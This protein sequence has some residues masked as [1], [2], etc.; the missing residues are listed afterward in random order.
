MLKESSKCISQ[1][2]KMNFAG[3]RECAFIYAIMSAALTHSIARSCAEGSIYTCTCGRQTHRP[4]NTVQPREWE[5][6][7]CSDNSQFGYK[8][9]RDFID[10]A[11]KE[12]DLKCLMN[13]HNSE[14]G[15]IVSPPHLC[16]LDCSDQA[17]A[18]SA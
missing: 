18:L 6:G 8:F 13:L 16:F 1:N 5:W 7:G 11:E 15:R 17:L 14:A 12:R 4:T 3:I 9:S 2:V 10:V